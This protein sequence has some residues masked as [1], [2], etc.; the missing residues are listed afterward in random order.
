MQESTQITDNH[1]LRGKRFQKLQRIMTSPL[2]IVA[3]A[4]QCCETLGSQLETLI[5]VWHQSLMGFMFYVF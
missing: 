4:L 3:G 2:V 5:S 1:Y